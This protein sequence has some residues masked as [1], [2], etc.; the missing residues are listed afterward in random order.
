MT[1]SV[2][3]KIKIRRKA[4]QTITFNEVILFNTHDDYIRWTTMRI[5]Y[6]QCTVPLKADQNTVYTIDEVLD[7][8]NGVS[9][10][11]RTYPTQRTYDGHTPYQVWVV[12]MDDFDIIE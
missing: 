12:S 5:P 11:V 10:G 8:D 4:Y 2:K 3:P 6:T 7:Y 1:P 9:W